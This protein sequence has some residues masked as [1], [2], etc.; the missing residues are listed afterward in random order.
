MT[1][2]EFVL[3]LGLTVGIWN[4]LAQVGPNFWNPPRGQGGSGAIDT[5]LLM[6]GVASGGSPESKEA[7]CNVPL[8]SSFTVYVVIEQR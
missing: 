1:D 6:I 5:V 3:I 4:I 7:L 2:A 8:C